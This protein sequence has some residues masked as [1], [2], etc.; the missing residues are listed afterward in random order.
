MERRGWGAI[1]LLTMLVGGPAV[2][3][4]TPAPLPGAEECRDVSFPFPIGGKVL[5]A[6]AEVYR[7]N[8]LSCH[9]EQGISEA[10][11]DLRLL[12]D[13]SL[14]SRP[15]ELYRTIWYGMPAVQGHDFAGRLT[16]AQAWEVTA[17]VTSLAT[18]PKPVTSPSGLQSVTLRTGS[19]ATAT[20][21]RTVLAHYTGWLTDGTKFDSSYD[22]GQPLAFP[23]GAGRVI[24]GWEEGVSGMRVGELRQLVIPPSLAYGP[25]PKGSIPA[26]STLIFQV[27]LVEVR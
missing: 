21:G 7:A 9:G 3:Q 6:G 10:G 14:G 27:E 26:N 22:R 11:G 23:L 15:G 4:E 1:L 8:C 13:Y 5:A 24:R 17:Y 25:R 2:S 16:P 19:G 12:A 20:P 18:P